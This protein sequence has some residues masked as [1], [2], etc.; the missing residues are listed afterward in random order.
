MKTL[1]LALT[2][3]FAQLISFSAQADTVKL[4]DRT[5]SIVQDDLTVKSNMVLCKLVDK[6]D[7]M[8]LA[9]R[10][11][12][13]ENVTTDE[14]GKIHAEINIHWRKMILDWSNIGECY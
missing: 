13:V 4:V 8:E 11:F 5:Y 1:I 10:L 3:V 6:V 7:G 12:N 2:L 9:T 14:N